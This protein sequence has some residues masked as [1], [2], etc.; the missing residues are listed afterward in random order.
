MG[1]WRDEVHRDGAKAS[2]V[3]ECLQALE[4]VVHDTLSTDG[5]TVRERLE[6]GNR[7]GLPWGNMG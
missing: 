3:E 6:K 1:G 5:S 4:Q 7:S 2:I